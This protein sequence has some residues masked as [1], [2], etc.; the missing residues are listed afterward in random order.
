MTGRI[1]DQA[2]GIRQCR[3]TMPIVATNCRQLITFVDG[4]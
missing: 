1:E 4:I 2:A 3:S